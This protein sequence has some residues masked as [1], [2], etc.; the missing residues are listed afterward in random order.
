MYLTVSYH[1]ASIYNRADREE[2]VDL[3]HDDMVCADCGMG[4]HRKMRNR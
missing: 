1:N 4:G 3:C 2:D